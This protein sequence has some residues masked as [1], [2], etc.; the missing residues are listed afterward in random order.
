MTEI[1][2]YGILIS[3]L[4]ALL[5]TGFTMIYG[6][7]GVIN[8][9][10]G[11]LIIFS[12]YV[13]LLLSKVFNVFD[14]YTSCVLAILLTAVLS[15]LIYK[16][17]VKPFM[18]SEVTVMIVTLVFALTVEQFI[19][20][21]NP[22]TRIVPNLIDGGV[23]LFGITVVAQRVVGFAVAVLFIVGLW[24]FVKKTKLG[25]AILASSMDSTGCYLVGINTERVQLIVWCISGLLAGIGG[26]F[27]GSFSGVSPTAWRMPLLLSFC[28]VVLGGMGNIP[29]ALASAYLIGFTETIIAFQFSPKLRGVPSLIIVIFVLLF[30]SRGLFEKS[31]R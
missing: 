29:G 31:A 25:K 27:L 21:F 1:L 17:L 3:S 11:T 6:V 9:A 24:F 10:H 30:R 14:I 7:G 18:A 15:V 12:G 16:V 13:M 23:Q 2:I 22:R 20:Y 28:I 8:L 4:Y 19:M 5:A 26:I